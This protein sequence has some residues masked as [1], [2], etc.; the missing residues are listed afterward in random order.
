MGGGSLNNNNASSKRNVKTGNVY[1]I[2][3]GIFALV[4]VTTAASFAF[5]TYSRTGET[6]TVITSGD[7]EFSYIEG[8]S[9]TLANAFPVAD[10]IGATDTTGEYTFD[11]RMSSTSTDHKMNYNVML[12]D[13][14]NDENTN[15]FNNEQIKFALIKDSVYVANT[16]ESSGVKLSTIPGFSEGKS[17]GYGY[18]LQDQEITSGKTDNYKLRIWISDDVTYSDEIDENGTMTGKYNSYKYS[19]K[20]KITTGLVNETT[21]ANLETAGPTIKAELSDPSGLDSY[22][23]TQNSEAPESEST[24][25]IEITEETAKSKTTRLAN[26]IITRKTIR[27]EVNE[28]GTYYLHVR[29]KNNEISTKEVVVAVDKYTVT[30]EAN[31]G[32]ASFTDK[33]VTNKTTYGELPTI[34]R[35]GYIFEGW[36][37]SNTDG[38]KITETTSLDLIDNQTLYAR[39][40]SKIF[41]DKAAVLTEFTGTT[42]ETIMCEQNDDNNYY[43]CDEMTLVKAGAEARDGT[44]FLLKDVEGTENISFN[45]NNKILDMQGNKIIANLGMSIRNYSILSI[46]DETGNGEIVSSGAQPVGVTRNANLYIDNI[47][48]TYTGSKSTGAVYYASS[49]KSCS[50]ELKSVKITS[51]TYGIVYNSSSSNSVLKV[52]NSDVV[53]ELSSINV[54]GSMNTTTINGGKYESFNSYVLSNKGSSVNINN[55]YLK[56]DINHTINIY[57]GNVEINGDYPTFDSEGNYLSG[58]YVYSN[59][60]DGSVIQLENYGTLKVNGGYIY[61]DSAENGTWR[62]TALRLESGTAY[63][64]G[65]TFESLGSLNVDNNSRV[66]YLNNDKATINVNGAT[67]KGGLFLNYDSANSANPT[68]FAYICKGNIDKLNVDNG[69]TAY[70]KSSGI[71]WGTQPTFGEYIIQDDTITCE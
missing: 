3:F 21:I 18:V 5:F 53:S 4:I 23:V 47:N 30:F 46:I 32:I 41:A 34:T 13:D 22:A 45:S 64:N 28:S 15:Y 6:T 7:I 49:C 39:W 52:N 31:G 59:Y 10:S 37:T 57:S 69:S 20:V 11:V 29:N 60:N 8:K 27:H 48:I 44:I 2:V 9:A 24:D 12:V 58:T 36:Y 42:A 40:T 63:L 25:W 61:H 70:I 43:N 68:S 14:N 1:A 56:S 67:I 51:I 17:Y 26:N 54:D 65:G 35:T 55:A 66:I 19:L 50:I 16:S 71:T 33:Q 62:Q 38:E